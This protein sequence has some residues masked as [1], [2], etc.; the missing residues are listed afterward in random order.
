MRLPPAI[1]DAHD[2]FLR[3]ASP[4]SSNSKGARDG[5]RRVTCRAKW[6]ANLSSLQQQGM[7]H[8][9]PQQQAVT[10]SDTRV[11]TLQTRTRKNLVLLW[12]A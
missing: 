5:G 6:D 7:L 4:P 8:A 1:L 2:V 9:E 10:L 3:R 12:R 11:A